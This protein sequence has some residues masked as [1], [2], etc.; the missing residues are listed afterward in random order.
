MRARVLL[1]ALVLVAASCA[2]RQK[3][4]LV[5][6]K[7]PNVQACPTWPTW[8]KE[9]LTKACERHYR[10]VIFNGDFC[11]C[12]AKELEKRFQWND[13]SMGMMFDV[14]HAHDEVMKDAAEACKD[15]WDFVLEQED[16][17]EI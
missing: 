5:I 2:T 16:T 15:S 11:E 17:L 6:L 12:Y 1:A 8:A 7:D 9:E 13:F 10:D 14:L 4:A 3:T